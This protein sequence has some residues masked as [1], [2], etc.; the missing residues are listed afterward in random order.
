MRVRPATLDAVARDSRSPRTATPSA[1]PGG[2]PPSGPRVRA[3]EARPAG[4]VPAADARASNPTEPP[5]PRGLRIKG[6]TVTSRAVALVLVLVVLALSYASMLRVYMDQQHE[7]AVSQQE[8][9]DRSAQID[10]LKG[11][12]ARWDDPAYVKA[13]ARERLGWVMPGETG[14][15]VVG[16]DGQPLGGGVVIESKDGA[17]G[18]EKAGQWWDRL[19]GSVAAADAPQRKVTIK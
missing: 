19:W 16:D 8:I 13:Q 7:I 3:S 14:Y 10:Q 9:R 1:R 6:V 2:R 4:D 15:R 17:A 11:E 18:N 5:A 12:L